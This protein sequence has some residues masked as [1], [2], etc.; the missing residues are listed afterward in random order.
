MYDR[1][2]DDLYLHP[3]CELMYEVSAAFTEFYDSCYC[4]EKLGTYVKTRCLFYLGWLWLLTLLIILVEIQYF[5]SD[6]LFPFW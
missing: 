4:I 2:A 5:N 6:V 1:V 3:I